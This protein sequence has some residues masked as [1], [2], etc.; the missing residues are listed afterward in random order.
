MVKPSKAYLRGGSR[1]ST[2][3]GHTPSDM[4]HHGVEHVE[5]LRASDSLPHRCAV[6]ELVA[7]STPFAKIRADQGPTVVKESARI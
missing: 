3:D 6:L 1:L 4:T 2:A 7:D 5:K